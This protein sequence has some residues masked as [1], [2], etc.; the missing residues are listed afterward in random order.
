MTLYRQDEKSAIRHNRILS[1]NQPLSPSKP[2]KINTF[3]GVLFSGF[4]AKRSTNQD[5]STLQTKESL[6]SSCI[7]V[8]S[9]HQQQN[10][11]ATTQIVTESDNDRTT[12]DCG[13]YSIPRTNS[14]PNT[15]SL[16]SV[17]DLNTSLS[18]SGCGSSVSSDN[19]S[20]EPNSNK[21][22]IQGVISKF[23]SECDFFLGQIQSA[24]DLYVRPTF[25]LE[26]LSIDEC[27]ELYQN[28]EKLIPVTKFMQSVLNSHESADLPNADLVSSL[29]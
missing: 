2:K 6:I 27:L 12:T 22:C 25:V 3:L 20:S 11:Q 5:Q 28:I 10:Q 21:V 14:I 9:K 16:V 19:L 13:Y 17:S 23:K 18:T 4:R 29:K 15:K 24:I 8:K 26:I 1:T 7:G